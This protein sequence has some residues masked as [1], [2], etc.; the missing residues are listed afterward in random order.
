MSSAA[1]VVARNRDQGGDSQGGGGDGG[2]LPA[3]WEALVDRASGRP[4]YIDHRSRTTHWHLPG[5]SGG[6]GQQQLPAG[7][8]ECWTP[9]GQRYFFDSATSQSHW[10]LPQAGSSHPA[11]RQ[12]R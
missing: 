10:V 11:K 1:L 2:L 3:G 7:W 5:P 6:A 4:Y 9:Q 8:H 12:A